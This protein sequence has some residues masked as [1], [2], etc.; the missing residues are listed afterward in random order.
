VDF[1]EIFLCEQKWAE[2]LE[3]LQ[4]LQRHWVDGH[5]G[6][7]EAGHVGVLDHG[8]LKEG[9]AKPL[10]SSCTHSAEESGH[11]SGGWEWPAGSLALGQQ[12]SEAECNRA[13]GQWGHSAM[14]P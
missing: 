8:A 14:A 7:R 6:A 9:S 12:C 1:T 3:R 5:I 10:Q 11:A 13:P 2:S 4:R